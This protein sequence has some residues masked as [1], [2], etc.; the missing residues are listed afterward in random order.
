LNG[1]GSTTLQPTTRIAARSGAAINPLAMLRAI[2]HFFRMPVP[3]QF[4]CELDDIHTL[5]KSSQMLCPMPLAQFM[6]H[7]VMATLHIHNSV[8]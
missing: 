5:P 8:A 1:G 7:Y 4:V 3:T 6:C 2:E